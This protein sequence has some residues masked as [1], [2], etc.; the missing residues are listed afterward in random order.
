ME[1]ELEMIPTLDLETM[2]NKIEKMGK[3]Q[4]IE[5][6][7]IIKNASTSAKLNE[8]KSGV[9]IN[10]TYL[11][12]PVLDEIN[13][14]IDLVQQQENSIRAFETK[15]EEFKNRYFVEKED[16]DMVLSYGK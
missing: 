6:L 12:K 13:Q 8:N 2:K 11:T 1:V 14:Y 9:F 15:H 3:Q 4:H 7:N 16:K 5:I 10:L